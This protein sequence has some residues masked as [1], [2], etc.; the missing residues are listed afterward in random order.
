MHI[1]FRERPPS[2]QVDVVFRWCYISGVLLSTAM[3]L[4][5]ALAL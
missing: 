1:A 3:W 5:W 2:Y 4:L